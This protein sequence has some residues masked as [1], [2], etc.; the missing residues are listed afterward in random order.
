MQCVHMGAGR[1]VSMLQ[2]PEF[3]TFDTESCVKFYYLILSAEMELTVDIVQ[4]DSGRISST[5]V[6]TGLFTWAR[7]T[8]SLPT[9]ER[10]KLIFKVVSRGTLSSRIVKLDGITFHTS[11]GD[12]IGMYLRKV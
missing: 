6:G 7:E 8:I 9:G 1:S 5:P 3:D 10:F 4:L 2:S 11:S 12:C